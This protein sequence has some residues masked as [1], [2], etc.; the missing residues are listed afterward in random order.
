M[1]L[2]LDHADADRAHGSVKRDVRKRQR[3]ARAVDAEHVRI[4]FL[5]GRVHERDHLGL[6]AEGLGEQRTDGTID[7]AAG[8]DFFF[9][10]PSFA[11]DKAA[12]DASARVGK[13]AVFDRQREEV[14]PLLGVGRG[15]RGARHSVVA[16]GGKGRAGGLFG[17]AP[18]F[19]F[20]M[21]AA[22]KLYGY[23][24]LHG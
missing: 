17:H 11:L 10:G 22:G 8:Q 15:D 18:G 1:E 4:V 16:G 6:I 23:V 3:A 20:D 5:V 13:L 2:A 12:R 9:A 7:L 14:D 21:L 19:E 24:M